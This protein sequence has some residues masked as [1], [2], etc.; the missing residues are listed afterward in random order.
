MRIP[1]FMG[2]FMKIQKDRK[3]K[4]IEL[5]A[6]GQNPYR[7][8]ILAGYSENYAKVHSGDMLE[9]CRKAIAELKPVAEE[10][11]KQEFKYT[12]IQSF[13]KFQEIQNLAMMPDS[14]GNYNNLSAAAKCEELKGK[15]FGA[16]EID[17]SQKQI[18]NLS[19][20][21]NKEDEE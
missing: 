11:I 12:A 2:Y 17:N 9:K 13:R 5:V 8:A 1:V 18:S 20:I 7:A 16:Y 10:A 4:F 21:V 19:I 15:L 3:Q 14:K 6:G